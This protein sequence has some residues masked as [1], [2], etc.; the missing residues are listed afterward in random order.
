MHMQMRETLSRHITRFACDRADVVLR[1]ARVRRSQR[2]DDSRA[3]PALPSPA[4]EDSISAAS[5]VSAPCDDRAQASVDRLSS[6]IASWQ[7]NVQFCLSSGGTLFRS[8]L[9]EA[10]CVCERLSETGLAGGEGLMTLRGRFPSDVWPGRNRFY[11][12]GRCISGPDPWGALL[13]FALIAV[14]TGLFLA[15][16]VPFLLENYVRTGVA[17]LA[18]TLPLLVVTLTSFFLT[19][20]DDPGI[21]P[22]Q[23]VDLFA[24]RIR[25]NAPLLRKKEVYYDGQRFVLKYCETCQLYRPPRCSHCS[26]CNNCVERFDHHC[27]WVSNCVGLRN[28]RTFFIF[29]S[30]CLVLS[31]L[32]V[33]YTILYLV[34]VS[35][36]KVSIGASSTGFAGF[37]RSLSNGPTA[38]SLVSLIIA[39]FGVVFTGA[40]TVFHTVLIF[41]NKTTAESFKYTFRGHASPFQPK[42]L[43]NLAKVLCSRKPPSKVKVNAHIDPKF[44]EMILID[45]RD[46][47]AA[48]QNMELDLSWYHPLDLQ[49]AP[50]SYKYDR[51]ILPVPNSARTS[52]VQQQGE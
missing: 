48:A 25:R 5:S 15:I 41:T 42:G 44:L 20:F 27:P 37:A 19:V 23:S 39:L 13:T 50:A 14:A 26:S 17:V 18:T 38:A 49:R 43:K 28:Y 1:R 9:R 33:A 35:N 52:A 12:R 40:L 4:P 7:V 45:P 36:Q 6:G 29:I 51:V 11:C 30:S 46:L 34:D 47:E 16:P 22:R 21:L 8:W 24:R 2:S 31:G 3:H 32:V 10:R